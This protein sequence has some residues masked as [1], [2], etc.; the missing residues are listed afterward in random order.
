MLE[1]K[2]DGRRADGNEEVDPARRVLVAK[3]LPDPRPVRRSIEPGRIQ[4]LG[5][6]DD[7]VGGGEHGAEPGHEELVRGLRAVARAEDEHMLLVRRGVEDGRPYGEDEGH[8]GTG[9]STR[10]P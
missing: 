8:R 10:T 5:E 6:H 7:A 4:E 1:E 2:F 9:Q 3:K